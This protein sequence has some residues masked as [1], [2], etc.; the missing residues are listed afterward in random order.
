[1]QDYEL[2]V[3]EKFAKAQRLVAA[4]YPSL[5][6]FY[7]MCNIH[8][9]PDVTF[10]LNT[11]VGLSPTLEYSKKFIDSLTSNT[12][13]VLLTI[14][15]FRLILHHPTSRLLYPVH[16]CYRASTII[17]TDPDILTLPMDMAVKEKFPSFDEV[18]KINPELDYKTDFY[19]EKIF[20]VLNS[21]EQEEKDGKEKSETPDG[22]S[23]APITMGGDNDG[24]SG[25]DGNGGNGPDGDS[26][27]EGGEQPSPEEIERE[28]LKRHFSPEN[29]AKSVEQWGENEMLDTKVRNQ[30]L[31]E[32]Q[33]GG[34]GRMPGYMKDRIK[35]YNELQY[36][37]RA[38]FAKFTRSVFSTVCTFTRMK[39]PR[40]AGQRYI[41]IIP[42]KR[43]EQQAK[44]LIAFDSSGS[45]NDDDLA[46][47]L[48]FME[49]SLRHAE[50]W[51]A[52]WD[53][54]CTDFEKVRFPKPAYD[55]SGRGGTNPQ[56]VIDKIKETKE[57][58]DGVIL[59][60]D[61]EFQWDQPKT[62]L[63]I[64][65]VRTDR[66]WDPPK[67]VKWAFKLKDLVKHC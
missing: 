49:C 14:E 34:W 38:I 55:L 37:P 16:I 62:K 46:K 5:T 13:C 11:R 23:G 30:I 45:M 61:C 41:G 18:K 31:R 58:F 7:L 25:I 43:H 60:T 64:C 24:S 27:G 17:C 42:G 20:A 67:W 28:S 9:V 32:M 2:S 59:F 21:K 4:L 12:L 36:D 48:G 54:T 33:T 56:C 22:D 10:R 51:Y 44:V 19:L 65:I 53:C 15:L 50:V 39:P 52:W 40:R 63:N 3:G 29:T 6:S 47:G 66:S 1:M 26:D 57:D 35:K 8:E